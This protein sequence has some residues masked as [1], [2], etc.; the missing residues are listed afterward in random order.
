MLRLVAAVDSDNRKAVRCDSAQTR[1][2]LTEAP[3]WA[4]EHA[5]LALADFERSGAAP[6]RELRSDTVANHFRVRTGGAVSVLV[7][8][9]VVPGGPWPGHY[10]LE[11]AVFAARAGA[12]AVLV[13][14]QR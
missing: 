11:T 1:V 12:P 9:L 7:A 13:P 6:L 14:E 4:R 2:A 10:G 5:G 3:P 8:R